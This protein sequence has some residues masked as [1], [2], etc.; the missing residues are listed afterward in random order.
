MTSAVNVKGVFAA[1]PLP[2]DEQGQFDERTFRRDIARLCDSGVHGIYTTGTTGEFYALDFDEFRRVV[3]AFAAETRDREVATQVGCTAVNNVEAMNRARYAAS[4][5]V[6]AIQ[7]ALPF[8]MPLSDS[9]VV[10]FFKDIRDAGGRLP[11]IHYNTGRTKRVLKARDYEMVLNEVPEV[12][13]TKLVGD[14]SAVAELLIRVPQLAHLVGETLLAP[15]MM[16][17]AKG[18]YSSLVLMNPDPILALYDACERADWTSAVDI[19]RQITSLVVEVLCPL[20]EEGYWDAAIDKALAAT[21]GFLECSPRVRKPYREVPAGKIADLRSYIE[22]KLP[23][24]M[25]PN[26]KIRVRAGSISESV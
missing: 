21:T 23:H 19:Q 14:F 24:L 25:H 16:L 12:A 4:K 5:G 3:D 9:E 20:L 26:R 11:I 10:D 13:G 15:A 8:W 17:G 22:Q 18:T 7:I 2:W 6:D 1:V